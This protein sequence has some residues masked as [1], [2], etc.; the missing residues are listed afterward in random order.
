MAHNLTDNHMVYAGETPW[1]KLGTKLPANATLDDMLRLGRFYNVAER[2]I[3]A[4][5]IPTPLETNKALVREDTGEVL[6]VVGMDYRVVQFREM[7]EM[8][9]KAAGEAGAV[10]H[11]AGLLGEEG[12][13]GWL[14]GE[15]PNPINVPGDT[16][17]VRKY[18]LAYCGHDGNTGVTL[19]NIATRVVCNNT[20]NVALDESGWRF[21]ARHTQGVGVRMQDAVAS[22]RRLVDGYEQFGQLATQMAKVRMTA[23]QVI[24]VAEQVFP[25]DIEDGKP[26]VSD[27]TASRRSKVLELVERG[28]GMDGIRGTA[29][30]TFQAFT[31][32]A[33]HFQATGRMLPSGVERA[34]VKSLDAQVSSLFLGAAQRTKQNAMSVIRAVAGI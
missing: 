13:K 8:V 29:W 1:H 5:G 15:L 12:A 18:F 10:F 22:F 33:D 17:E 9:V 11:T 16:S 23:T 7:G 27:S 6:S 31:E 28:L 34:A 26:T 4:Q 24:D 21:S 19:A 2:L 20:L 25:A 32:Y 3:F 30:G 14:M